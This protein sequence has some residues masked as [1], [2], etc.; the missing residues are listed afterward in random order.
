MKS[1]E[2]IQKIV[3]VLKI[4]A[5]IAYIFCIIGAVASAIGAASLFAIDE[6]SEIWKKALEAIQPDTIDLA[7][8]RCTCLT[9][10]FV[11][12]AGAVLSWFS[13]RLFEDELAAGTPFDRNICKDV[14]KVGIIYLAVSVVS[15]IIIAIIYACF[16][17]D[18]D[19]SGF[20]GFTTGIVYIICWLLCRYGADVKEGVGVDANGNNGDNGTDGINGVNGVNDINGGAETT[21]KVATSEENGNNGDD[22]F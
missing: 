3:K 20:S 6:N 1:L 17:L 19:G 18:A 12:A 16:N 7:A 22:L 11:C 2:V 9:G 4:L 8:V 10:V 14:L 21:G 15:G 5:K 13:K